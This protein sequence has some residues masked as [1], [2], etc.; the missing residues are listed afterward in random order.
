MCASRIRN[1]SVWVFCSCSSGIIFGSRSLVTLVSSAFHYFVLTDWWYIQRWSSSCLALWDPRTIVT[2]S[3]TCLV[4]ALFCFLS[5][6]FSP[7]WSVS[8]QLLVQAIK[9][10]F[11]HISWPRCRYFSILRFHTGNACHCLSWTLFKL[12]RFLF[13]EWS[14]NLITEL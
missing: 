4:L 3:W 7:F 5:K 10:I 9:E 2:L 6:D 11:S 13:W 12:E 14:L 1:N 8:W